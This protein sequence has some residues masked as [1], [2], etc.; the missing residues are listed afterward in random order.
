MAES[1]DMS[2]ELNDELVEPPIVDS[3]QADPIRSNWVVVF[4]PEESISPREKERVSVDRSSPEGKRIQ[5]R[6][7]RL[8][9]LLGKPVE[10]VFHGGGGS[11]TFHFVDGATIELT[12]N[13]SVKAYVELTDI[14][15]T[16]QI[17]FLALHA[18]S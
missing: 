6:L 4:I 3:L 10:R 13:R 14:A 12:Q 17:A 5:L 7:D 11:F 8:G 9:K 15:M 18:H 2:R 1:V 16:A